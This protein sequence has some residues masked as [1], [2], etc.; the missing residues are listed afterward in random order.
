MQ[1]KCREL[2]Y[3]NYL[4]VRKNRLGGGLAILWN[5]EVMMKVKS[6]SKHHIDTM[7]H[8]ENGCY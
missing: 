6:Y 1:N 8:A 2:D 4:E 5:T 7:I 3:K